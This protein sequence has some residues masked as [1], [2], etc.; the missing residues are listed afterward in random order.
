L[1]FILLV[2]EGVKV[3]DMLNEFPLLANP[4]EDRPGKGVLH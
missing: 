4:T 1:T 2:L 3:E